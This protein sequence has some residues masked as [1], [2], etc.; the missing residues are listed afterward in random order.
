MAYELR[1]PPD[2][3]NEIVA[4]VFDRFATGGLQLAAVDAI[5]AELNK[6][7]VNPGLGTTR[8]GGPFE[9][10]PIYRFKINVDSTDRYLQVVYKVHR[11]DGVVVITGFSPVAF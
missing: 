9:T 5:E 7:A 2:T 6:L 3:R 8:P 11:K 10:R 4:F 1:L